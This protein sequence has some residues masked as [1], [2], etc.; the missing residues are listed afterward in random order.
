MILQ[1]FNPPQLR[2][3]LTRLLSSLSL[4][5]VLAT[6]AF[7]QPR[8]T[9]AA[10]QRGAR[11]VTL[12]EVSKYGN[13]AAVS[14]E[15]MPFGSDFYI[16]TVVDQQYGT[17]LRG[18]FQ[19]LAELQLYRYNAD[20]R[21][22][23]GL[24]IAWPNE[25]RDHIGIVSIGEHFVWT[26]ATFE[27][28]RD[29]VQ[30]RAEI[31]DGQ[32]KIVSAHELVTVPQRD[33][34]AARITT[35]DDYTPSRS[36]YV[37]VY[38]EVSENRLLS[39][40]DDE[41]A[42]VTVFVV[43]EAGNVVTNK[44][45]RLNAT[46]DQ[47]EIQTATVDREGR[48]YILAK[49]YANSKGREL[50]GGSDARLYLYTMD[51]GAEDFVTTEIEL[52]GQYI[53]GVSMVPNDQGSPA[54]V[55]LYAD[56]IGRRIRGYFSS[57]DIRSGATLKPQPFSQEM[58][59]LMGPKATT[60]VN[61]EL[62]LEQSFEFR[63]A[64]R[65]SN[66]RLSLLLE[67]FQVRRDNA[68]YPGY[69]PSFYNPYRYGYGPYGGR[70]NLTFEYQEGIILNFDSRGGLTDVLSVPKYQ[71]T[72]TPGLP[73]AR[74]NLVE[75]EGKAAV[76]YNDNPKNFTRDP[77]RNAKGTN[78]SDALAVL[79]YD[80]GD[81]NLTRIPLFER[82][83]AGKVIIVP[84]SATRLADDRVVFLATR[85]KVFGGNELRFGVIEPPRR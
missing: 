83:E 31:L 84:S 54:I 9:A 2:P 21:R 67:G 24:R 38:G 6:A 75:Y 30:L 11:G 73:Y 79:G 76:I 14:Y 65:L 17:G 64:L 23:Q 32:G 66:G 50:R 35:F 85:Y 70:N 1:A 41:Q 8:S 71:T 19:E 4:L 81:G 80:Q 40:K 44:R 46:R 72:Q 43:D 63:D 51:P 48:A 28:G 3:H 13:L 27:D 45:Q 42:S 5:L 37:R 12:S 29:Q 74:I 47:V 16:A 25:P 39:K 62:A 55:G 69:G 61:G 34:Q 56:R 57:D 58:L 78:W 52:A 49:V 10:A 82:K 53:Q 77:A 59:A 15:V 33:Y 60:R 26:F 36:H 68:Y 18:S 7:A 22:D 20:L